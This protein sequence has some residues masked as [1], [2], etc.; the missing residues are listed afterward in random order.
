MAHGGERPPGPFPLPSAASPAARPCPDRRRPGRYCYLFDVDEE[1]A[2]DLD[3]RMRLV[4]RPLVDRPRGADLRRRVRPHPAAGAAARRAGAAAHRGR[5]GARRAG[6]RPHRLRARR[7]RRPPGAVDERRRRRAARLGDATRARSCARAW[8]CSTQAFAERIRPWPQILHAL[9]RRAVR[10]TMELNVHRAATCHPR[11]DAR[12]A[13]LLWHLAERWGIVVAGRH[14]RAAAADAPADRTARRRRAAV[15]VACARAPVERRAR[16]TRTERPRPARHGRA[17]HRRARRS[18]GSVGSGHERAR[19]HRA[20]GR[21]GALTV[22]VI[23]MTSGLGCDGDT[24]AMTAATQPSLEDLLTRALPGMPGVALYNPFLAVEYR[25]RLH[26]GLLRRGGRQARPV[27]PR[28][29]GR[30]PQRGDQRRRPLGRARHR[31]GHGP[32]DHHERV[33]RPAGAAGRRPCWRWGPAP[34]TAGSRRCATTPPARWACATTSDA[35]GAP[36]SAI[37]S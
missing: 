31:P 10:R 21:D 17:S 24:V 13:L 28:A 14:P 18:G 25:P 11:A 3:L 15:G 22:H 16:H 8:R 7:G 35:A 5:R 33:D 4:A 27:H 19:V 2:G 1:L 23:W 32:A 12:I 26:A 37:R 9:L 20:P 36:G 30:G 6:R 29:R 34:R